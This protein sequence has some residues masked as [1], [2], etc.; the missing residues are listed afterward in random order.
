MG[1]AISPPPATNTDRSRMLANTSKGNTVRLMYHTSPAPTPYTSTGR[2]KTN[3]RNSEDTQNLNRNIIRHDILPFSPAH[4]SEQ[5]SRRQRH[6]CMGTRTTPGH[7][8][9]QPLEKK[10]P[11]PDPADVVVPV[12]GVE[13]LLEPRLEVF[14]VD[15]AAHDDVPLPHRRGEGHGANGASRGARV[16]HHVGNLVGFPSGGKLARKKQQIAR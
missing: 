9:R 11:H 6:I 16:L 15:G 4:A 13:Y 14:G 5:S 3:Q 1:P 2:R 8:Q 12:V 7:A 10:R